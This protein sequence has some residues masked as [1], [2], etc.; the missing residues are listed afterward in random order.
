MSSCHNGMVSIDVALCN[1]LTNFNL[2][3]DDQLLVHHTSDYINS[4]ML[5]ACQF[6]RLNVSDVNRFMI[7][8]VSIG[9]YFEELCGY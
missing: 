1:Q 7:V 6:S 2:Y 8:L 4:I 5:L 3:H 9:V